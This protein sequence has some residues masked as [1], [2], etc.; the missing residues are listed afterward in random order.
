MG[1]AENKALIQ[2]MFA[3]LSKGNGQAFLDNMAD[4][5]RV[6]LIGTTVFSGTF[7]GKKEFIEKVLAPIGNRLKVA[8]FTLDNFIADGDFVACRHAASLQQKLEIVQQH[9]PSCLPH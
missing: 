7:N 1:A 4:D 5:V 8:A 2:N 9:V 3:E 6:T